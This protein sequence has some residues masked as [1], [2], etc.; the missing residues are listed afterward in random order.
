M[1]EEC[2]KRKKQLYKQYS[3]KCH[4]PNTPLHERVDQIKEWWDE[5]FKVIS[6]EKLHRSQLVDI[7]QDS[8]IY[9]RHGAD[10]LITFVKNQ[11]I[12]MLLVS[13]GIGDIVTTTMDWLYKQCGFENP[14]NIDVIS[15]MGSYEDDWL[16][17]FSEPVVHIMNKKEYVKGHDLL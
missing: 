15:N 6:G 9:M 7:V 12:P 8:S 10:S 16:V 17:E 5:D 13:A 3:G 1:S 4:D 11:A 2:W 14:Q